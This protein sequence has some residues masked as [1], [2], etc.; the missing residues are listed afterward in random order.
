MSRCGTAVQ[1]AY[2]HKFYFSGLVSI[3]IWFY[4]Q[5]GFILKEML[6]VLRVENH[7]YRKLTKYKNVKYYK[8]KNSMLFK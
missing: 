7:K 2:K 5:V 3:G 4:F 8:N 6:C 1:N